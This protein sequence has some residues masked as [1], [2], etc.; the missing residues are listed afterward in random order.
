[1]A[2]GLM[3]KNQPPGYLHQNIKLVK[4]INKIWVFSCSSVICTKLNSKNEHFCN[5]KR[6]FCLSKLLHYTWMVLHLRET[7]LLLFTGMPPPPKK[8]IEDFL[9]VMYALLFNRAS[10]LFYRMTKQR[11]RKEKF[12]FR[13]VE[14]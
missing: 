14:E 12:V 10:L 3:S 2:C 11:G 4:N 6:F 1:M 5:I 8:K 7:R 9:C 13:T